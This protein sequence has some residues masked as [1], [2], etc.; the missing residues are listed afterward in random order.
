LLTTEENGQL[1]S[2]SL[3]TSMER[4]QKSTSSEDDTNGAISQIDEKI[5][6]IGNEQQEV[7]PYWGG[8]ILI[9][10]YQ[11]ILVHFHTSFKQA[12]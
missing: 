9:S 6:A 4:P 3:R 2:T 11:G 10:A 1:P 12:S 5:A 7:L 8:H